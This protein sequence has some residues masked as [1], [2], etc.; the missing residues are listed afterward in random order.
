MAILKNKLKSD[1][2]QI[3]NS[4]I[5]DERLKD[6]EFRLLCYLY[7][8]PDNWEVNNTDICKKL[9]MHRGTLAKYWKSLIEIGYI[10]RTKN[11]N[12]IKGK[13]ASYDYTLILQPDNRVAFDRH[14]EKPSRCETASVENRDGENRTYSNTEYSSNTNII[15]NT[16]NIITRA[17]IN[18]SQEAKLILK[19][20]GTK[21]YDF[22]MQNMNEI[23]MPFESN[24]FREAWLDW[25]EHRK[26]KRCHYTNLK[27]YNRQL[28][29]LKEVGEE[30]AIKSIEDSIDGNYQKLVI[31]KSYKNENSK[32]P[33]YLVRN[34]I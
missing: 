15:T 19:K 4:M 33:T 3:P 11:Q 2:S 6:S 24:E 22:L 13:F 27:S 25:M 5:N 32:K 16:E 18:L 30:I 12:K 17:K 26:K 21:Q 20:V 34:G 7:S 23:F 9:G 29:K 28:Q 8:K 14:G 31:K 1:F 10:Q